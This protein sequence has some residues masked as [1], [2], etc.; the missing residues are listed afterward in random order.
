M[1]T[2][3]SQ[4]E[5]SNYR[6]KKS[7]DYTGVQGCTQVELSSLSREVLTLVNSSQ[8]KVNLNATQKKKTLK[9]WPLLGKE[10]VPIMWAWP[11]CHPW[12]PKGQKRVIPAI[13]RF[14]RKKCSR[15]VSQIWI[16]QPSVFATWGSWNKTL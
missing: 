12:N 16:Q 2:I 5:I 10:E 1:G 8:Q 3:R 6:L 7:I 4:A 14:F 13:L 15:K 11:N 9:K